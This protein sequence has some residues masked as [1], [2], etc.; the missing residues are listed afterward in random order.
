[1][2]FDSTLALL[3]TR[4]L[5]PPAR[6]GLVACLDRFEILQDIGAGGMGLVFLARDPRAGRRV[7]IKLL[8]P[9]LV[10]HPRAVAQFLTEARHLARMR[11]PHILPVLEVVNRPEAPYYVMPFLKAGALARQLQSG[12][13]LPATTV[14]TLARQVGQALAFAH[15][16]GLIHRD[17]K[18]DNV[19]LDDAGNAR[20]ADFGLA[21]TLWHNVLI[22]VNQRQYLGTAAYM[23]P[24]VAVGQAEDTRCDI[25]AFGALLYEMLAGRPPYQGENPEQILRRVRAGPPPPLTRFNPAADPRLVCIAEGAMARELRDRYAEMADVVAD[26][27]RVAGGQEPLGPRGRPGTA[28]ARQR[29]RLGRRGLAVLIGGTV[30]AAS[31][32]GVGLG[33]LTRPPE[34]NSGP[35]IPATRWDT[36]RTRFSIYTEVTSSSSSSARSSAEQSGSSSSAAEGSS[37]HEVSVPPMDDGRMPAP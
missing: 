19:L 5:D 18:P 33:R 30:V 4:A 22:D 25:Y 28:P 14:V 23:S 12:R 2:S 10:R 3:Q 7:A 34:S 13:P 17:L 29:S 8:R 32:A 35:A 26:L 16:R 31:L 9:E 15:G 27:E 37:S 24:A 20:L 11:H 36:A 1:M 6:P 21:R